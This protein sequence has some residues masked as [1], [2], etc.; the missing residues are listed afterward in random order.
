MK[1]ITASDFGKISTSCQ[2]C[3][4]EK[5]EEVIDLGMHPHSDDFLTAERLNQVEHVFPLR[6][7]SCQECGLLQINFFVNPDILYRT[8][9]VY[10]SSVTKSGVAHY[11]QM[12]ADIANRFNFDINSSAL[13]VDIGSN[14]GV[15]LS[16]FKEQGFNVLGV[17]PA[18]KVAEK[19]NANGVPT[20]VDYFSKSVAERIVA[21]NG[22]AKVITGTNVFAHL[23]DLDSATDGIATL[24]AED[25][26]LVIEA[27]Y[28]LDFLEKVEYDTVYHQHIGYLSVKPMSAY[29][30]KFNLELFD[31]VHRPI[32][33]GTLRYYVGHV[34]K[35]VVA[36]A[37]ATQMLKEEDFGM[38]S[39]KRLATFS[40]EVYQQR[41]ELMA[42]LNSIKNEGKR[43]VGISA[44]AKG[45]TLLNFCHID[46]Y[47]LEYTTEKS[48]FKKG[49]YTPGMHVPIYDDARLLADQPDYALILAWNFAEEIMQNLSEYKARGGKFII[50]IPHPV[51]I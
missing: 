13:A 38:Y 31:V 32:H 44:P 26:V 24:L 17:D 43:I 23:H 21:E 15:L 4:S 28:A 34:G 22:H 7:V 1:N 36:E 14:V 47:Y 40:A 12:A 46:Q 20:I 37:I 9:Y 48:E 27:P 33:G 30:K 42:L 6:L 29:F 16:G 2:M 50:P 51:V 25:G 10:E 5:L 3:K 35:H 41:S 18:E 19:A 49:L 39:T 45:N 8:N 11:K